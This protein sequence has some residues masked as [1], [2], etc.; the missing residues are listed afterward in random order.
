[1]SN[2]YVNLSLIFSS[3]VGASSHKHGRHMQMALIIKFFF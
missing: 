3:G 1:M 2:I